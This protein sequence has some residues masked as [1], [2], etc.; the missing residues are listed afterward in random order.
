M[1]TRLQPPIA[2]LLDGTLVGIGARRARL[3]P[4]RLRL[5]QWGREALGDDVELLA[6]LGYEHERLHRRRQTTT[7]HP[8]PPPTTNATTASPASA[9]Y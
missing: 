1:K 9:S 6:D 5:G 7:G 4:R 8:S 2:C 3:P